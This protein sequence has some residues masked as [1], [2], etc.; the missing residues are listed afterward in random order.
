MRDIKFKGQRVDNKEWV[1]GYGI[2]YGEHYGAFN[3]EQRKASIFVEYVKESGLNFQLVEVILDTV[4]QYT[5]FIDIR[6][7]EIYEKDDVRCNT[8]YGD[9][10][11]SFIELNDGCWEVAAS[12]KWKREYLKV[13]VANH[14]IE[15]LGKSGTLEE[16]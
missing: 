11:Y 8:P 10:Y 4:G 5:E 16:R 6:G 9:V 2:I 1:Y 15:V 7:Q 3:D 13:L 14:A 12:G